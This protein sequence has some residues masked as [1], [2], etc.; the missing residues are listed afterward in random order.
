MLQVQQRQEL[1]IYSCTALTAGAAG[2]T[3]ALEESDW[4]ETRLHTHI[5]VTHT[6]RT[7]Q[8]LDVLRCG[9]SFRTCWIWRHHNVTTTEHLLFLG[10]KWRRTTE[11]AQGQTSSAAPSLLISVGLAKQETLTHWSLFRLAVRRL[12]QP[13]TFFIML[14]F[15]RQLREKSTVTFV[16]DGSSLMDQ[17]TWYLRDKRFHSC[18]SASYKGDFSVCTAAKV[19]AKLPC[20]KGVTKAERCRRQ[21]T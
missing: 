20:Q 5:L 1:Q 19:T 10:V 13:L 9:G 18:G 17:F 7:L 8:F 16:N 14:P 12:A 11:C 3:G 2:H 21:A 15:S 6:I 4:M